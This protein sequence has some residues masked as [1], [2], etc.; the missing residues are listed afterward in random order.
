MIEQGGRGRTPAD[1]LSDA[2]EGIQEI[3]EEEDRT[4]IAILVGEEEPQDEAENAQSLEA[5]LI[6]RTGSWSPVHDNTPQPIQQFSLSQ[7]KESTRR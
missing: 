7:G 2:V 1:Q 4:K 3:D 6:A 5:G